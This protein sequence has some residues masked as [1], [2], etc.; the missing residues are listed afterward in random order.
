MIESFLSMQI[1]CCAPSLVSLGQEKVKPQRCQL[2]VR[3][4]SGG[5][6]TYRGGKSVADGSKIIL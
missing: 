3:C 2:Q 4:E 1:T 6:Q 5:E